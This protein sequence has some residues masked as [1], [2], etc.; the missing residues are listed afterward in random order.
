MIQLKIS[1]GA[2]P[3]IGGVL[4]KD[5]VT[6]EI[7]EIRKVPPYKML[8]S[9]PQHAELIAQTPKESV[10]KLMDFIERIRKIT[11]LPVG[12][13][14]CFGNLEEIELLANAMKISKKGPD[15]IQVDGADGGTG[16]GPNIFVNY[17]GYGSTV[18]TTAILDKTLK[19]LK[20][21][22]TVT[23]SS[24]GKLFTPAHAASAFAAGADTIET[25]RGIM[26]SLGCIQALKC[27]T[28]ECPTGITTNKEWRIR[29][30]HIPEKSTRIHNYL[31]GF[32]EDMLEITKITGHSDPRDIQPEDLRMFSYE[33]FFSK[34]SKHQTSQPTSGL[35]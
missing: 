23:I 24:S 14:I 10:F 6:P 8:I 21:R 19:R 25:A 4:P 11:E 30:I 3:G 32:H 12:I 28:N 17:V 18:E 13:K 22:D 26:L 2:K 29:A 5:K 9:P 33:N 31:T 35:V 27:H 16:A 1:Q 15:A 34:P 7:A 20:I